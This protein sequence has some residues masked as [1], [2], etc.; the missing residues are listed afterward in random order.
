MSDRLRRTIQPPTHYEP[1]VNALIAK[2]RR[3]HALQRPQGH[4]STRTSTSFLT[5]LTLSQQL[6]IYPQSRAAGPRPPRS[7]AY[8]A[9]TSS[10]VDSSN[11]SSPGSVAP[12][13]EWRTRAL[14][15]IL[16][17]LDRPGLIPHAV[18]ADEGGRSSIPTLREMCLQNLLAADPIDDR[19]INP[20]LPAHIRRFI[21]RYTSIHSPL[22]WTAL[23]ELWGVAYGEQGADGEL[24]FVGKDAG[25]TSIGSAS[26]RD[27]LTPADVDLQVE[28]GESEDL[29]WD[30]EEYT[31]PPLNVLISLA[32]PL[33][34]HL[35][36]FPPTITHLAL[37]ATPLDSD[38][39]PRA[40]MAKLS[41]VLHLLEA[42]D[43]SCNPW[44]VP[45]ALTSVDWSKKWP[46]LRAIAFINCP[47]LLDQ[48]PTVNTINSKRSWEKSIHIDFA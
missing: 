5:P 17:H 44:L 29:T 19:I 15:W 40:M 38:T 36:F 20:D 2:S 31:P 22:P 42:L 46:R 25:G 47:N 12:H 35:S 16:V 45:N 3:E 30:A 33:S 32:H 4:V 6:R 27:V 28:E 21:V 24:I 37:I 13:P 7:W 48:D 18:E 14:R 10:A 34:K 1:K 9:P 23:A 11:R 43:L 41:G 39:T 8:P 26:I